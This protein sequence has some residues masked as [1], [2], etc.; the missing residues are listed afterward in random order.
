MTPALAR[1][2]RGVREAIDRCGGCDGAGATAGR[3]RSSAGNWH[4]LNTAAFPPLDCARALDEVVM[5]DGR[6]PP[7][8]AALARELGGIFVPNIDV[9]AADGSAS[10]MVLELARDLGALS[11][12]VSAALGDDG[13]ID[14]REAARV[15]EPA[16]QM[17]VK[18]AQLLALLKHIQATREPHA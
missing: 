1:I 5:A 8:V 11:G 7:I 10:R 9:C 15:E 13:L 14:A 6:E 2:K 16:R 17:Q 18:L 3:S 4:E 12:E